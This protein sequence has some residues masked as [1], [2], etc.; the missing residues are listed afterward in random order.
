M[1]KKDGEEPGHEYFRKLV[2]CGKDLIYM[3]K[4]LV[5]MNKVLIE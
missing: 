2:L 1:N 3:R 5:F 4:W